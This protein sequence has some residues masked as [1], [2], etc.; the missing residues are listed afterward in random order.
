MYSYGA[1]RKVTAFELLLG[2]GWG[3]ARMPLPRVNNLTEADLMDLVGE[4]QALPCLAVATLSL[5]GAA[6]SA[7]STLFDLSGPEEHQF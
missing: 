6:R 7:G 5:L 3:G 1:D 2:L 4:A